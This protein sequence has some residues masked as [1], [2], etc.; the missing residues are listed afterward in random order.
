MNPDQQVRPEPLSAAD[1]HNSRTITRANP[2]T[3]TNPIPDATM[4]APPESSPAES[5]S[6]ESSHEP[7][8]WRIPGLGILRHWSFWGIMASITTIG[9]GGVALASLLK[10]PSLPNCPAIFLPTSSASIRLYCAE[11][12]AN[13]QTAE[14]LLEAIA[15]IDSLPDDHPLRPEINQKIEAWSLDLL[16]LADAAFDAG[17]LEE[18]I[19]IVERIPD[20]T[21]AHAEI[22]ARI[23]E[24]QRIWAN[25]TEIYQQAETALGQEDLRQ[26]F[27]YSTQLLSVGNRYW[28]TTKYE[29]LVAL[30]TAT[31]EAIDQLASARRLADRGGADNL[32]EAIRLAREISP[33]SRAYPAAQ[34]LI[35]ELGDRLFDLAEIILDGGDS[36]RAIALVRSIPPELDMQDEVQD[37]INLAMAQNQAWGGTVSDLESAII[38]AQRLA[39]NRP[40]YGRAQRLISQWQLEIRDVR[41]L[42]LAKQ[43][44]VPGDIPA[45]QA[46]INE[47]SQVP[48]GNP[49]AGE[50]QE[51]IDRWTAR[52]QTIEDQ[53]YLDRAQQLARGGNIP[54]WQ[55]A[56]NEAN[57]VQPGRA[58]YAEAQDNISRWTAQIQRVQDQP[59][60]DE[61]RRLAN[62]GNLPAAIAT[63]QQI[64]AGR[65]LYDDAQQLIRTWQAQTEGQSRMADAYEAASI[66]TPTM[67][68]TA[69]QLADQVPVS[70]PS[71]AEADRMINQ[72]SQT[73]LAMAQRQSMI[74]LET[75]IAIAASIPPRTEA[76]AEAQLL[77]R[78]WRA[79]LAQPQPSTMTEPATTN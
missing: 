49:R 64:G 15:Q 14:D 27:N 69:I 52:I 60:L 68:T 33:N 12:A 25:A 67:L 17:R 28:A 3:R 56:I 51:L 23:E 4:V 70:N 74:D 39:Q 10:L 71:R 45:L 76:Y 18:A 36:D 35:A 31:R 53:P 79:M 75:A 61:A 37:F 72:W 78:D 41:Q 2:V 26:A 44:A 42:D 32:Q 11:L 54:A 8:S 7:R 47:A 21:T 5:S 58:L 6:A 16:D 34:R 30:I 73:L 29:E 20:D 50:A 48:A 22:A 40:L 1:W 57:Q 66:G 9:L 24:W 65:T 62:N 77:V 43:L 13:K 59:Y 19:A 38:Q 46:A 63:A 55:A